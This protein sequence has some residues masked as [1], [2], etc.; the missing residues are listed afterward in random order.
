MRRL[1]SGTFS[2]PFRAPLSG[3]HATGWDCLI[4]LSATLTVSQTKSEVLRTKN[5]NAPGSYAARGLTVYAYLPFYWS[6]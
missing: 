1:P 4:Y 2:E 6:Q 5:K 3:S